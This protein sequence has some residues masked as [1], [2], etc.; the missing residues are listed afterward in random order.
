MH[1]SEHEY[2]KYLALC[3][4]MIYALDELQKYREEKERAKQWYENMAEEEQ[5][6]KAAEDQGQQQ[7]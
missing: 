7:G 2:R 3:D 5:A 6:K 4:R 1:L